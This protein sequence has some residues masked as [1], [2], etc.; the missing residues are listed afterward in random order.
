[1][2]IKNHLCLDGIHRDVEAIVVGQITIIGDPSCPPGMMIPSPVIN[3][4]SL[5]KISTYLQYETHGNG[6]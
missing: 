5:E 1:M 2:I 6:D 3:P 4:D